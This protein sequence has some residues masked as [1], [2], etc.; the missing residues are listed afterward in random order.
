M[1]KTWFF[2][3]ML[4]FF[5]SHAQDEAPGLRSWGAQS[6]FIISFT[7]YSVTVAAAYK[8]AYH[9]FYLGPALSLSNSYLPD[10]GP[11]G[12]NTGWKYNYASHKKVGAFVM[13][14]YLNSFYRP[15]DPL[16]LKPKLLNS[17]HE[18][19]LAMGIKWQFIPFWYF[20]AAIGTGVFYERNHDIIGDQIVNHSGYSNLLKATFLKQ[21]TK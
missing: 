20:N 7:G 8:V 19:N 16:K 2:L 9:E 13:I 21:F 17:I 1:K 6:S 10:K 4:P 18:F 11:W 14:D 15:Y 12:V 3:F 5:A